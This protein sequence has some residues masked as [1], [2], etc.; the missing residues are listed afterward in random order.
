MRKVIT[1]G[2]YDML[3]RGH[4]RLLE[5][6]RSLGDYLVVGVTSDD[7]DRSRGKVNVRQSL[8]ERVAAV[9]ATG[10]ADEVIVEEY[11]GQKIDD[12]RRLGVD[13]FTVG[14]DWE[15]QFDYLKEWCEV[16]YLP[17]TE[18]VS[19]SQ[20]RS[21]GNSLRLGVC[22]TVPYASKVIEA[23]SG[24]DGLRVVDG[25]GVAFGTLLDEVDAVMLLTHPSE[26][27]AQAT[28]ALSRGVHVLC[29]SPAAFGGADERRLFE[30]AASR[31]A[32]LVDAVKTAYSTAYERLL[33]LVKSGAIGRVVSVDATCTS[34]RE[35]QTSS[36]EARAL[37]W[38]SMCAWGP[39][40]MLPVFHLLGTSYDSRR[41]VTALAD[42]GD[43]FDLFTK[44]DFEYADAVAS[45]KVGKGVKSEG[46]LVV[47]GT[48]GYV[49]V[50]APWWKT[51]YFEVR[52]EDPTRNRRYFYQLDG[53]GI[54][55]ELVS[56][57]RTVERG[58]TCPYVSA[59]VSSAIAE[60]IGV[61]RNGGITRVLRLGEANRVDG[62]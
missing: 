4:V 47:T 53:E 25:R 1:Y 48:E 6:A 61:H 13:V 26:H 19:S 14:S 43:G 37:S 42:G 7:Y 55:Y 10:L 15:G 17:R 40:A 58:D 29:E 38:S 30:L 34:L 23:A 33:L 39:T 9:E 57:M 36:A 56:F 16:V 46:E 41:I 28:E 18:G 45:I 3:H 51:D 22:G 21:A 54:P 50:P 44:V 8:M 59:E 2:T 35:E 49:Y 20:I 27:E 62:L 12:V 5:R 52:Y 31:G 60:V 32:T 11:P 24:V